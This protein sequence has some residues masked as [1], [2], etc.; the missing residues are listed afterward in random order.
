MTWVQRIHLALEEDRFSLYAQPIVPLGEGAEEAC[1]SN[2]CCACAT[3]AGAWC[4]R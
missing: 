4:R 2:C 3:R 1:T